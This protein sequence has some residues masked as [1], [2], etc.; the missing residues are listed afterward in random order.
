MKEV[1]S[2]LVSSFLIIFSILFL[3]L[4]VFVGAQERFMQVE[5]NILAGEDSN[6]I[7]N[8]E[9][10]EEISFGDVINGEKSDELKIY[11]NNTG[12]IKIKVTPQLVNPDDEIF[13]NLKL[14]KFKSGNQSVYSPIGEFSFNISAPSGNDEFKAEY[15][16][17]L[18]DLTD[19]DLDIE[20]DLIGEKADIKFIALSAE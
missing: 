16:Y 13:T 11:V 5:A 19:A 10:P 12:N 7:I 9:F 6:E 1:K 20:D 18:L 3:S 8:I 14:R 2:S 15:F 17:M 4:G